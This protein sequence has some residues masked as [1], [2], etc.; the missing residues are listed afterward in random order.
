MDILGEFINK[1]R[2]N[3]DLLVITNRFSKMTKTVTM[4]GISAVKV[5]DHFIKSWMLNYGPPEAPIA[6][7][8]KCF[9]C[10][11]FLDLCKIM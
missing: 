9:E 5:A 1:Q 7:N 4:K 11:L 3:E 10:K 8:G 2:R 6:D